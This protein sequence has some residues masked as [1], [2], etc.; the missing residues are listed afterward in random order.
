MISCWILPRMRNV[1][2]KVVEKIK[3]HNL[4]S[5]TFFPKIVPFM[6][7]CV[8]IWHSQTGRRWQYNTAPPLSVLDN[9]GYRYT[10]KIC[11][12]YRF[13]T[14]TM[15]TRTHL[16]VTLYVH[17]LSVYPFRMNLT[18]NN[19]YFPTRHSQM[20]FYNA[21]TQC[22]LWGTKWIFTYNVH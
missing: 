1:S 5:V 9:Y 12:T 3:T 19:H 13:C 10:L 21:N 7:Q 16:N 2:D 22:F 6:R 8:K 17:S 15:V 4:C 18:T 14:V 20:G 11:H